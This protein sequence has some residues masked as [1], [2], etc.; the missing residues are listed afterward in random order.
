MMLLD[1]NHDFFRPVWR[2]WLTA[3]VPLG[4]GAVEFVLGS[5]FWGIL[6]VAAGAYAGW[7]FLRHAGRL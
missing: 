7:V 6:F 4:W 3:L 2:R 1:P 5:P